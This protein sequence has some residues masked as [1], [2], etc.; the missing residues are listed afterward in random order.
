MNK[1][2]VRNLHSTLGFFYVGLIISFAL[3]GL[4]M[5]HR[6][7][8][9]PEKYTIQSTKIS[10][11]APLDKNALNDDGRVEQLIKQLG[12]DDKVRR[13]MVRKGELRISCGTHD[14]DVDL[15]TGEGEITEF[16]KTPFISQIMGLHKSTS[17][18]WIY[19]SDIFALSLIMIAVTGMLLMP[20]QKQQRRRAWILA[21]AGVVFPILFILLLAR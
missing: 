7:Y 17:D 2:K 3:S 11:P 8:W 19:Y 4:M 13:H 20:T 5:N 21:I 18:W 6:E 1:K 16:I 12:I 9:Q 14:V 15:K 10:L